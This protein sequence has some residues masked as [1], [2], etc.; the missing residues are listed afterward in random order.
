M[1][2]NFEINFVLIDDFYLFIKNFNF[3]QA[4]LNIVF[5]LCSYLYPLFC[6]IE[7]NAQYYE[8]HKCPFSG[9]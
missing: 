6:V 3:N 4:K 8:E 1:E 9:E 5:R 2:R 7:F